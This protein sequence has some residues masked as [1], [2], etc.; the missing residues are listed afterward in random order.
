MLLLLLLRRQ[1]M[2]SKRWVKK[3]KKG[4]SLSTNDGQFAAPSVKQNVRYKPKAA[5]SVPKKGA[6]NVG[7]S[8]SKLMNTGTSFNNDNIT[9]SNSFASLNE[10]EKY[11]V[12]E[13]VY[14]ETANLFPK[15]KTSG[16]S[17]FTAVAG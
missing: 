7:N 17:S 13:N 3:K 2:V 1:M 5:T 15:I 4:N 12:V 14:D 11:D 8:S 10:E 16:S 9:S 6:T